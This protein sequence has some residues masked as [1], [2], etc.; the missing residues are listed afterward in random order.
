MI[1]LPFFLDGL[2]FYSSSAAGKKLNAKEKRKTRA[3][4]TLSAKT[5]AKAKRFDKARAMQKKKHGRKG[6]T[7]GNAG[8]TLRK[9]AIKNK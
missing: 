3:R 7:T 4:A 2:G 1:S 8:K 6:A 5:L 9:K